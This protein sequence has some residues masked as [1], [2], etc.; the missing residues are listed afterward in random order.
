[1]QDLSLVCEIS[2]LPGKDIN[3]IEFR[4]YGFTKRIPHINQYGQ[5]TFTFICA[6]DLYEKQLFDRWMDYMLPAQ[7][8]IIQYPQ[9]S[10]RNFVYAS[11]I[12]IN[13]RDNLN[14]IAYTVNLFNAMPVSISPM[15]QNWQDDS[16]HR[17]SVTFVY[18]KW[19]SVSTTFTSPATNLGIPSGVNPSSGNNSTGAVNNYDNSII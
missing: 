10:T 14:N 17:L 3:M 8:G 12:A 5:I 13:Q 19:T 16:V 15:S 18:E 11:Q 1:M 6:G 7:T 2:E 4:H 9:D